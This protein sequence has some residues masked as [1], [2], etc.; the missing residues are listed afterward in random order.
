[1]RESEQIMG[2][3]SL[4]VKTRRQA[5]RAR[6]KGQRKRVLLVAKR[7][8]GSKTRAKTRPRSSTGR[9]K[10]QLV[11]WYFRAAKRKRRR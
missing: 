6:A 4:L 5:R 7:V 10:R 9:P 8:R 2:S 11:G 1:M 3:E